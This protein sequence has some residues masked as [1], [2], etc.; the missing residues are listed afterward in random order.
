[1]DD[2]A[3]KAAKL[4][5]GAILDKRRAKEAVSRA[6]GQIAPS[7]YLPEVPRQAHASGGYVPM[8][9]LPVGRLAVAK[10]APPPVSG[11]A[12]DAINSLAAIGKSAREMDDWWQERKIHPAKLVRPERYQI[13]LIADPT[14]T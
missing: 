10:G 8:A 7:K 4:T 1:M 6:G 2:K 3:I 14:A 9:S 5:A 13:P 12:V 11:G